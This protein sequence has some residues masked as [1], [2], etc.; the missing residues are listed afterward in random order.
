M[1]HFQLHIDN[2]S[3]YQHGVLPP[4]AVRLDTPPTKDIMKKSAPIMAVLCFLLQIPVFLRI[5]LCRE[6]AVS[7]RSLAGIAAGFAA[8]LALQLVH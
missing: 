5:F 8:G 3:D 4:N 1:I 7:I 6:F 2:I